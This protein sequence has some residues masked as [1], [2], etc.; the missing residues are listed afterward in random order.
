M[1]L[2]LLIALGVFIAI[3]DGFFLVG[4][5]HEDIDG[6]YRRMSSN[7]KSKDIYSLAEMMDTY[8]TIEE[9]RVFPPTLI[10]KVYDFKSFLNGYIKVGK[11]AL[12]GHLNVQ[13]FQFIVLNDVL[14]LRYKESIRD[15]EWSEPIELW[16]VDEPGRP[17]LPTGNPSFLGPK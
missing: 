8:R 1:F 3:D 17:I 7:L 2:S 13:Y 4:H 9:K 16:N 14:V 12:V 11:N 6:A 15:I 5:T 10:D